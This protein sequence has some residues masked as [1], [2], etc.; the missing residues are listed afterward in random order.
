M[1]YI[2]YGHHISYKNFIKLTL[3]YILVCTSIILTRYPDIRNEI[4]YFIVADNMIQNKNYLILKYF[5]ELYPDKP[6]L[7]FWL[8]ANVKKYFGDNFFPWAVFLGS[9]LPSYLITIMGYS[10]FSKI[11]DESTGFIISLIL[12]TIPFFIGTS[13]FLRMDMLMG[14]FIFMALSH[15]FS[16]YYEFY[17]KSFLNIF[18]LYVFIFLGI[19]TKG[20]GGFIIPI[21]VMTAFLFLEK[22]IKF[23]KEIHF[24]NG[25]CLIIFLTALWI[26]SISFFPDG[27]NYISLML[28]QETLGRIVKSKAHI[29]PFYYY[30]TKLPLLIFPYEIFLFG[31]IIYYLKNIKSFKNWSP[32]E[33]I[34][35]SWVI[36]PFLLLSCASGKLEIYLLP[37]FPGMAVI[38]CSFFMRV[39]ET[40][41]GKTAVK[42]SIFSLIFPVFFNKIFNRENESI[43]KLTSVSYSVI[44]FFIIMGKFT[45]IYNEN[46]TLKPVKKIIEVS[47]REPVG[48][49]FSDFI[50]MESELKNPIL[51]IEDRDELINNFG[52]YKNTVIVS[53]K[54][55]KNDLENV[56]TLQLKYENK[57]YSVY[58]TK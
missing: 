42:I 45:E 49:R 39:K 11:K 55:Y 23:F 30:I 58:F 2:K 24:I 8:L 51:L 47:K 40:S 52:K 25:I 13:I 5:T 16:L 37:L 12:S 22:N 48:Y 36:F 10:L 15:F 56:P 27:K 44:I 53:R 34:G 43:K 54:K 41:F 50:N 20:A 6:P 46:F 35:F 4:K 3:I 33:K 29:Q 32:L 17:Q 57:N 38:I 28:G 18:M 31:G 14:S 1:D 7:Y 21:S 9:T 19:F 26:F